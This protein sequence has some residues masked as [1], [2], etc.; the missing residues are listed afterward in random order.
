MTSK[1]FYS[2][3]NQMK[4]KRKVL[5][6]TGI[7]SEYDILFPVLKALQADDRFELK[8]AVSGAHLSDWHGFTLAKILDDGFEVADKLDCLLMT[9]RKTQR[10]KST[11]ILIQSLTQ[12]VDREQPDFLLF[13]GDREESIATAIVGNYMDILVAHIGGGDPVFG[14]ADDPIRFAVSKLAHIHFATAKPYTDNLEQIG[15]EAFRIFFSGNPAICNIHETPALPLQEVSDFLQWDITD[16]RYL[17]LIKHPLSSEKEEAAEQMEITLKSLQEFGTEHQV[18]TV[19]IFPNTDPGA[20]DILRAIKRYDNSEYIHFFKTLPREI[21]VN[22]TRNCLCLAGN[23]SMGILEAPSYKLPVVNIGKRQQG[24]LNAG[25]VNFVAHAGAAIKSALLQACFD[26]KYRSHIASLDNPYGDGKAPEFIVET[27]A[28]IDLKD[29]KW[30]T[31]E[32][33]C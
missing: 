19:G 10:P 1:H 31:K 6:V 21:F 27:L 2:T 33:L 16:G 23:S 7:R 15:E 17:V 22:L 11:G 12:T 26:E 32:K 14:N 30:Y 24:R 13:V 25:N 29:K 8:I 18:K 20:Y 9:D 5:A 4:T 3:A 28:D